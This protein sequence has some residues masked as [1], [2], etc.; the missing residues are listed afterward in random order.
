M[1]Q[2]THAYSLPAAR[3][4][5]GGSGSGGSEETQPLLYSVGP[6]G[7]LGGSYAA[8]AGSYRAAYPQTAAAAS[9]QQQ[10]EEEGRPP[11]LHKCPRCRRTYLS[12]I[13]YRRC[14]ASHLGASASG[15]AAR[16]VA[17]GL[18]AGVGLLLCCVCALTTTSLSH[19]LVLDPN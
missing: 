9:A 18:W 14:V 5:Y 2:T 4:A 12:T 17:G 19:E 3:S 11:A 7:A 16:G 6:P 8:S 10:R 1:L 13:N 15:K